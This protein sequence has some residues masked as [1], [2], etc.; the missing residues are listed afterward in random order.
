MLFPV[1]VLLVLLC[2]AIL[3][4]SIQLGSREAEVPEPKDALDTALTRREFYEF[5]LDYLRRLCDQD[6]K[7]AKKESFALRSKRLSTDILAGQWVLCVNDKLS[8]DLL[9]RGAEYV[10]TEVGEY[11]SLPALRLDGFGKTWFFAYRFI[12]LTELGRQVSNSV[13][14]EANFTTVYRTREDDRA[15]GA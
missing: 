12:S 4:R 14:D 8:E 9:E 13:V 6:K 2:A 7:D 3:I 10:V 15:A 1:L 5:K 11:A